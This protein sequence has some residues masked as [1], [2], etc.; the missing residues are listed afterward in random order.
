VE[1]EAAALFADQPA[2]AEVEVKT[3]DFPCDYCG[4]TLSLPLDLAGKKTSCPECKRIIRVPVPNQK[5]KD[6]RT[7]DTRAPLGA[8]PPDEPAP[9]G[10]WGS[11]NVR[12]ASLEAL[13]EA[14][15]L[16]REPRT[17]REKARPFLLAGALAAVLL[18]GGYFVWSWQAGKQEARA[19]KQ[20]LDIAAADKLAPPAQGALHAGAGVYYL[21]TRSSGCAARAREQFGKALAALMGAGGAE[22]DALLGELALA[23]VELGGDKAEVDDGVRLSWDDTQKSVRATLTAMSAHYAQREA[24]RAVCRR[25]LERGQTQRLLPLAAQVHPAS[26]A[27]RAEALAVAG[28][29]LHRGGQ[30]AEAEKAAAQ[31][32]ELYNA[33][34]P[35]GE[36][37]PALRPAVVALALALGQTPPPPGKG[38]DDA[39]SNAIGQAQG[40]ALQ[41]Q[42]EDARKTARAAASTEAQFNALLAVAVA[43]VEAKAGDSADVEAA[44]KAAE[45]VADRRRLSWPLL[46]LVEFGSRAGLPEERVKAA[47]ELIP[48]PGV[49]AWAQLTAFRAALAAKRETVSEEALKGLK[50]DSLAEQVARQE[51]ARHNVRYDSGWAKTVQGWE[52]GPRAFGSLGVAL[53]LQGDKK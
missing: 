25:L 32:L 8:R 42:L 12:A 31:V 45:G 28:L 27:N 10:A 30:K 36:E 16:P 7:I 41:G 11:T 26:G 9:E 15:A 46:R 5:K 23:Q 51:L 53:G 6:W 19:L 2:R 35:M 49:R 17:F 29:E 4:E 3:I 47:V 33:E 18:T 13:E 44:L 37:R 24:L 43:A 20:A 40:Q 39:E 21:R 14:G 38:S 1:A 48:D 52:E 34:P 22:H 50:P